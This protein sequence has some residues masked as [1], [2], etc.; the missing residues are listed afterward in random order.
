MDLS[1]QLWVQQSKQYTQTLGPIDN[2]GLGCDG[3]ATW[4]QCFNLYTHT[5]IHTHTLYTH[6][7]TLIHIQTYDHVALRHTPLI[8][9]CKAIVYST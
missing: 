8:S 7:R 3:S 1:L 5:H 6:V 4:Y 2:D 9:M